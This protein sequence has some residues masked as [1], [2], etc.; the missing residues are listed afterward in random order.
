MKVDSVR[1]RDE[2]TATLRSVLGQKQN[3]LNFVR[4]V[5]ASAVIFG[6]AWSIGG[7]SPSAFSWL[8]EWAV[9]GF[10]AI[11]GYL[12]AGSRMRLPL[13]TFL[14]H[15]T[16][17]IYPAFWVCLLV[18]AGVF[19]P[20]STLLTGELYV[21]SSGLSYIWKNFT[22]FVT[23]YGIDATLTSVPFPN[24][25]NAPLWTLK[26]EFAAYL[27]AGLV[28]T[29]PWARRKPILSTAVL[30]GAVVATYVLATTTL[31]ITN[32]LVLNGTRLGTFFLAGMLLYFL[33]NRIQL[34]WGSFLAAVALLT[35]SVVLDFDSWLAPIPYA[36][37]VLWVG[38]K[39][40]IRL[41]TKND[42][43]YGVYIWAW[44]VQQYLAILDTSA[45]GAW[46]SGVLALALTVPLAWG[47]WKLVEEPSMR[48][49]KLMVKNKPNH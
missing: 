34:K 22:L 7:F 46:G 23:Q 40:P 33:G 25:W 24:T 37:I 35:V 20:L 14:V 9:C 36:F 17:R 18:V 42:I 31:Q 12:I 39:L 32:D 29:V 30:F 2:A 44:P 41:G 43:S 6:H 27:A 49:R 45:L 15:R 21:L 5:L 38:A 26:Y 48:L 19:A 16:L 8:G 1:S 11:S 13:G 28:L 3:A 47:S 10:F 4:L